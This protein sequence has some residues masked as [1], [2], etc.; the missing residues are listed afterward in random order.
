MGICFPLFKPERRKYEESE[1]IPTHRVDSISLKS[2]DFISGLKSK[3]DNWLLSQ[4]SSLSLYLDFSLSSS[5]DLPFRIRSLSLDT[6]YLVAC[7][8]E[9]EIFSYNFKSQSRLTG[10]EKV[11]NSV[12]LNNNFLLSGSADW[13]VRLWDVFGEAELNRNLINWN[14][15]TSLQWKDDNTAVQTSEDLRLRI[16]DIREK[17][18]W[19]SAVLHVGD[20]FATCCDVNDD[21]VVT[22]HRGCS[23]D[24]GEVKVWDLRKKEM[25]VNSKNHGQ[26]VEAVKFCSEKIV[27]AG[28]DGKIFLMKCDGTVTDV[29]NH[30]KETPFVVMDKFKEGILAGNLEP[31]V[32][33]FNVNPLKN[34]I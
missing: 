24:G 11:V 29:W 18:I 27:S 22:G 1:D 8:K 28:K 5:I 16:W 25:V 33:F 19:K 17:Q 21:L 12:S 30:V 32:L 14:V 4:E 34:E 10:H 31:K 7:N 20:N 6:N 9:I 15:V 2:G 23:G 26:S 3:N 13:T